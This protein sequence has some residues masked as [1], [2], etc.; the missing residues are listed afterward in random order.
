MSNIDC[1]NNQIEALRL[2]MF[3]AHAN[4]VDYLELVEISQELDDLMNQFDELN[5]LSI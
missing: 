3:E 4:S 2:K 1:I 5:K